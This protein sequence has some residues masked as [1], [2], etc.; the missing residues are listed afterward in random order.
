MWIKSVCVESGYFKPNVAIIYKVRYSWLS[1]VDCQL[2]LWLMA[3]CKGWYDWMHFLHIL[4]ICSMFYF[5][6]DYQFKSIS[7]RIM[8]FYHGHFRGITSGHDEDISRTHPLSKVARSPLPSR[9]AWPL[10]IIWGKMQLYTRLSQ[11]PC[12]LL[13]TCRMS[14]SAYSDLSLDHGATYVFRVMMYHQTS[15]I[16]RTKSQNVV[17]SLSSCNC[18]C[19]IYWSQVLSWEWRC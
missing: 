4:H 5:V 9:P 10:I 14:Y 2:V 17:V 3:W 16:R 11:L 19:A 6:L 8:L 1:I 13:S 18:F 15:N 7:I 12:A